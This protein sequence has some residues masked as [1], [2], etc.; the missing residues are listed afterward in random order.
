M[1][2]F[3]FNGYAPT[4]QK[5]IKLKELSFAQ[6]KT[7][8]KFITN[9]NDTHISDYFT[10]I[11]QE[12]IVEKDVLPYLTSYDKFC[13]LLMLRCISVSPNIEYKKEGGNYKFPLIPFL[14]Q[15]LDIKTQ[16]SKE[17]KVD[18]ITFLLGLPFSFTFNDMIDVF[19]DMLHAVQTEKEEILVN[20]LSIEEK[21]RL[22]Q[23][24]PIS[25]TQHLQ[26]YFTILNNDFKNLNLDMK[27]GSIIPLR[28]Y[29]A[30][31][32]ELLKAL[33]NSNLTNLYELQYILV[34]KTQFS[35]E[36]IDKNT[37]AENLILQN[38]L[39]KEYEKMENAKN[40]NVEK[41]IP[42]GK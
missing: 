20:K 9:N 38:L 41:P 21:N 40:S 31:M 34:S 1:G 32:L 18:N 14:Q 33:Y 27:L 23:S 26:D 22:F 24:I 2:D 15:C 25:T 17:I 12:N 37:L 39:E 30:S 8:N 36:Y 5:D 29:D 7:L 11:L 19:Y 42:L 16:F 28:P 6:Y 10:K 35:A 3:F 13:S 4:L